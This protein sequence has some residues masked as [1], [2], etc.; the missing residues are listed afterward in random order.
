VLLLITGTAEA[1]HQVGYLFILVHQQHCHVD[2][3]EAPSLE[4]LG[5]WAG[6]VTG[7]W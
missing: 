4:A 2:A 5:E 6:I 3:D 1:A 7:V